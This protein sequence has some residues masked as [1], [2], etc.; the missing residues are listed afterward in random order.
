MVL[1]FPLLIVCMN[2]GSFGFGKVLNNNIGNL[3][4]ILSEFLFILIKVTKKKWYCKMVYMNI[5]EK[6]QFFFPNVFLKN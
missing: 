3:H 4:L 5:N 6:Y 2:A 1:F